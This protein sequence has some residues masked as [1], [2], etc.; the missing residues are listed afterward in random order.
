MTFLNL[1][2]IGGILAF[3]IPIIIHLLNRKRPQVIKWGA[4]HL[5]E[6]VVCV[7]RKRLRLEQIILLLVRAAIPALLALCMMA[8][9]LTGCQD[10]AGGSRSSVVILLDN[11]YSMSAGGA[12]SNHAAATKAAGDILRNL[13]DG[14][15]A[16]VVTMA[17][18]AG[19]LLDS[20]TV[21]TSLLTDELNK[22]TAC[23]GMADVPAS[24]EVGA[25]ILSHMTQP[26]RDMIVITDFQRVSWAAEQSALRARLGQ[27]RKD[28]DL[29][30]TLT[31]LRVGRES[32]DNMAITDVALSRVTVGVGQKVNIRAN[33]KNFGEK[34]YPSLRVYLDVD[35]QRR[36]VTEVSLGAGEDGQVIFSHAFDQPGS[37]VVKLTADGDA[38]LKED[39]EYLAAVQV[40]DRLPI[41]LIDGDPAPA[42]EPLRGETGFLSTALQPFKEGKVEL[43]D[44]LEARVIRAADFKADT[45][46]REKA[47]VL[48]NVERLTDEQVRTLDGFVRGGGGL[49]IFPGNRINAEWY[50]AALFDHGAGPL[51]ARFTSL[52]GGLADPSQRTAIAAQNYAHPALAMFNDRRN[53]NLSA[54]EISAWYGLEPAEGAAAVTIAARL[55]SGDPLL[56]EKRHGD[57]AVLLFATA[58]DADWSNLPARPFYVPLMQQIVSY[59]ASSVEPSRNVQV[60]QPLLAVL[61]RAAVGRRATLTDPS[62]RRHP[63][64]IADRGS[65]GAMEFRDTR[66]LGL[67]TLDF[68]RD[69]EAES[70]ALHFVVSSPRQESDLR[71]LSPDEID[72]LAADMSA[73]VVTSIEEYSDLDKTRRHG[74]EIWHWFFWAV[75]AMCFLELLLQFRFSHVKR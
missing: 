66:Q 32:S 63:I 4:M 68:A 6:Q 5:L 65:R 26:K 62:G 45:I 31:F 35:G 11:S 20:P 64:T 44:L 67:Y 37:H 30:P 10:L 47:V 7:N 60:G 1:A 24:L 40:L 56:M 52:K 43:A 28:S 22:R 48:A 9:V 74:S 50:N 69:S 59:A 54:S 36:G 18:G 73:Q 49:V 38:T 12:N 41:L 75:L 27:W 13:R 3:N 51:P 58:C 33:L 57:G 2:M 34:A 16:S 8:P 72:K 55:E 23:Y 61:P 15:D 70:P 21:R 29:A 39:N 53:G 25:G 19:P 17:G 42:G 46:D 14:S 71:Q